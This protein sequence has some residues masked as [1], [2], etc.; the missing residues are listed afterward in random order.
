VQTQVLQDKDRNLGPMTILAPLPADPLAGLSK[1]AVTAE[2]VKNMEGTK[3]IWRDALAASHIVAWVAP[4]NGG[5]TSI[6]LFAAEELAA[7]GQ[8]VFFFQEDAAAGDLPALFARAQRAGYELL[9]STLARSSPGEQVAYLLALAKSD[10][11]LQG[12]VF[13]FD[14][15]KKFVD[16]MSKGSSREFFQ[17]L[18]MLSGRGATVLLLGHTNKHVGHDGKPVFEGVGDVRNDVDELA[19]LQST[20]KD[21]F[22]CV[23]VTLKQDKTR[24]KVVD[25]SFQLDTRT[26]AVTVLAERVDVAAI[27]ALRAQKIEDAPI[28][29]AIDRALDDGPKL[30]TEL[31]KAIAAEGLF[32]QKAV[33][34]V[35]DRY[36]S[37]DR[38]DPHAIWHETPLK[39]NARQISK[40]VRAHLLAT[41]GP[42]CE[43]V[44]T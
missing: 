1:W 6:A 36:T 40:A 25:L 43:K 9:N 4:G 11:D 29:A 44:N 7:A 16:L 22:G 5:K 19:Y 24:C 32:G 2:H 13:I 21:A 37:T 26:R 39:N 33:A 10:T 41:V 3:L 30:H 17:L 15:L 31:C 18:R 8:R 27:E 42:P 34:R 35:V 28:I 38:S 20:E 14:T 23:T 12:C